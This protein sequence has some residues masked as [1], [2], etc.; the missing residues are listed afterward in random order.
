LLFTPVTSWPLRPSDSTPKTFCIVPLDMFHGKKRN[1]YSCVTGSLQ[2]RRWAIYFLPSA[3]QQLRAE[4]EYV[5]LVCSEELLNFRFA[6]RFDEGG[7]ML[8]RNIGTRPIYLQSMG[9][10]PSTIDQGWS[11]CW[12]RLRP[13]PAIYIHTYMGFCLLGYNAMSSFETQPKFRRDI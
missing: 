2:G 13:S 10:C 7:S 9:F 12:G 3:H 1:N 4:A 8:L 6:F 11:R 5:T